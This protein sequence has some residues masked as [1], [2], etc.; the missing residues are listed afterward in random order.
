MWNT[1]EIIEEDEKRVAW[2]G[3]RTAEVILKGPCHGQLFFDML[4]SFICWVQGHI[5]C[6]NQIFGCLRIEENLKNPGASEDLK[7]GYPEQYWDLKT[8]YQEQ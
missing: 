4:K 5:C 2:C 8:G 1:E 3:W 6:P 7:S